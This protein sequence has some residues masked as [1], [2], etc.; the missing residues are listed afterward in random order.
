MAFRLL[1]KE[2]RFI[3][4]ETGASMVEYGIALIVVIAVG[5]SAMTLVGESVASHIN[6]TCKVLGLVNPAGKPRGCD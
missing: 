3:Q 6:K 4:D 2:N 5:A 1:D